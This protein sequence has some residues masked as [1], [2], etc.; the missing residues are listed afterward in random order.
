MKNLFVKIVALLTVVTIGI[1]SLNLSSVQAATQT[2]SDTVQT[3]D[4]FLEKIIGEYVP[5]FE[6]ATFNSEYDHYWHDYS[7]AIAGES[8][9]DF[10]TAMMKQSIGGTK[11]GEDAGEEFFCGFTADV[12][13]I[14]FGGDDGSQITFTLKDGSTVKHDYKFDK[15]ATAKGIVEG[16]DWGVT[17]RL[18]KSKDGNKDEFA[19][20]FMCPDTPATTYHLEFRY[21]DSEENLLSLTEGKYRNWLAAA[22]ETS[23]LTDP[24]EV[25]LQ[26][27]IALFTIE[28]LGLMTGEEC[29]VQRA[30]ISGLWDMDTTAFK[31]YPEYEN[32]LMYIELAKTGM[33]K[34]FVDMT[35]SGNFIP[36][37]EYPFY[38]YGKKDASGNESG[39]YIVISD[40]EGVKTATYDLTVKDGRKVLTFNSS[41]GILTY[42]GKDVTV[43][44]T[45]EIKKAVLNNKKLSLKWNAADSADGYEILVSSG[46]KFKKAK[47]IT[48]EGKTK[49]TI[50]GLKKKTCYVRIR[51][52]SIDA[53]GNKVYGDY[54]KTV[55][56]KAVQKNATENG[57]AGGSG[58]IFDPY[59]IATAEQLDLVR[60]DLG[61]NYVLVSD[62]DL[63]GY[64]NWEPI[65]EFQSKS[66][67]PEDVEI[68]K[69]EVAFRGTFDGQ[70]HTV[71]G[72][73]INTPQSMAVGL[74]GCVTGDGDSKG[75]IKNLVLKNIDVTGAY[76]VGGAVGLQFMNFEIDK[77][78][79]IGDNSLC[80]LQGV[81]GIVGTGF[82][83]IRNCTATANITIMGDDG[84]C[85]GL[86][87]GGTTF[88][89][90]ENC[91]AKNGV[92]TAAGNVCWGFGS[93]CGAPY[94]A[95]EITN[96]KA[97][98]VTLNITGDD[99]RLIGGIV[100]F[101][102]T[103]ADGTVAKLSKCSA[104][105]VTIT[106]SDTATCVGGI[107]GGPKEETAGSDNI[108]RYLVSDCS[109]SG[110]IKGGKTNIGSIA[111][112]TTNAEVLD[113]IGEMTIR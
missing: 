32:A 26:Q 11:Y 76:L 7:A 1:S 25:V 51:A 8:A 78:K 45:V 97:V 68:P 67:A 21:G 30:S 55:T 111:G 84:A 99:S 64:G 58:T 104:T 40:D 47:N 92:I 79:L 70:G 72:L 41:E 29:D 81:G 74:F 15:E 108:S 85:A 36:V 16:M 77:I 96:C 57:F 112:D 93:I 56:V 91:K 10:G 22:I 102:G 94:A 24:K 19:Y 43:P 109:V 4:V 20:I 50:K 13:K 33:G 49:A 12:T 86:I 9:A 87:A 34:S 80:G 59:Q 69:A 31:D 106:V 90:I 83:W 46:K 98:N 100:G 61:A 3:G 18:Y 42:Y 65:G 54:S 17:G 103:Y 28:N 44:G 2:A 52:F 89:S 23:A 37:S 53:A 101:A 48:V 73:K 63:S 27:V 105:K 14:A 62:I 6:G 71:S 88:S 38:S 110:M 75:Y 107:I 60:K 113:C 5:L 39:V 95:S 35:G 82:D 66:D